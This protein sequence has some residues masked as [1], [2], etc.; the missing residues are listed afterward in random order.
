MGTL[1]FIQFFKGFIAAA[2]VNEQNL[3]GK[4]RL[5]GNG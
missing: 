5:I 1:Q 4:V 3:G 2:I